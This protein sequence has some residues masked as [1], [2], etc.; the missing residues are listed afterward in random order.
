MNPNMTLREELKLHLGKLREKYADVL[1]LT[2]GLQVPVNAS[3]HTE[4]ELDICIGTAR[5]LIERIN[6]LDELSDVVE[7]ALS[8]EQ[9]FAPT[10]WHIAIAIGQ[11]Y[12]HWAVHSKLVMEPLRVLQGRKASSK[13]LYPIW[14]DM[15]ISYQHLDKIIHLIRN[16][17]ESKQTTKP[18]KPPGKRTGGHDLP[19]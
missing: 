1:T 13:K 18:R 3:A 12:D 2:E 16:P 17:V 14:A 5:S 4:G 9:I 15:M 6:T 11:L 19:K 8:G 7:D 10:N